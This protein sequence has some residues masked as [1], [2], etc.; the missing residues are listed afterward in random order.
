MGGAVQKPHEKSKCSEIS[1]VNIIGKGGFA[2]VYQAYN[3]KDKKV[4]AVKE[5]NFARPD[6]HKN[7]L[8]MTLAELEAL[9]HAGSHPFLVKLHCAFREGCCCYL[10]MDPLLGGDLRYHLR[11]FQLFREHHVAYFV[12]CIGSAL[13]HLHVRGILH[14]DVKPENVILGG[15]GVPFLTDF[16]TAFIE[17]DKRVPLCTLSS[18]TLP[19]LSPE[20]LTESRRHSYQSDYWSLGVLAFELLFNARPFDKHCPKTFIYFVDNQYKLMWNFIE[21]NN[22]N[23]NINI[24]THINTINT[25]YSNSSHSNHINNTNN[26]NNSNSINSHN[27]H[28]NSLNNN[29]PKSPSN[30]NKII[31][32]QQTEQ[33][34]M[35][36]IFSSSASFSS[37]THIALPQLPA[38]PPSF[39]FE[40]VC[41]SIDEETRLEYLPY[42]QHNIPLLKNGHLPLDF[43]VMIP[44]YSCAGEPVSSECR[45]MLS[46]LLDVRIPL[47]LG[48]L[49]HYSDFS[50]HPW[51]QKFLFQFID[52]RP[53]AISPLQ[54]NTDDIQRLLTSKFSHIPLPSIDEEVELPSEVEEKLSRYSHFPSVSHRLSFFHP[55]SPASHNEFKFEPTISVNSENY[56]VAVKHSTHR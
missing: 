2:V 52:Q 18:G 14:R 30:T 12:S 29:I 32:S 17:Q 42:P 20:S 50:N 31:L 1:I 36:A 39:D 27:H 48:N 7:E 49:Q 24:N 37:P 51:L 46:G 45:A 34:S 16:G 55:S 13:H 26:T 47:R 3:V 54:P 25:L 11:N 21:N 38:K 56:S 19:Y 35:S 41:A 6:S 23:F 40:E 4:V 10:V 15:T 9:K 44:M 5:T 28:S 8:S 43:M 22:T 53:D 33:M